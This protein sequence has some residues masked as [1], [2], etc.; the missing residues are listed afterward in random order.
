MTSGVQHSDD[1]VPW[2]ARADSGTGSAHA[3]L[4]PTEHRY[5]DASPQPVSALSPSPGAPGH[6]PPPPAPSSLA[7][8]RPESKA[9]SA[10]AEMRQPHHQLSHGTPP[11]GH[12]LNMQPIIP[13]ASV[14]ATTFELD[15]TAPLR[16]M[17]NPSENLS[18]PL[19]ANIERR[20]GLA[21]V[22]EAPSQESLAAVEP[23]ARPGPSVVQP[24]A[25]K[26]DD[27]WG[28]SFKIEWIRTERLPFHRTRHLRNPWNHGREVK[29]SRDGTELE[30]S[31]GRDLLAEWDRPPPDPGDAG[32][33]P[34]RRR[35]PHPPS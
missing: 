19:P 18:E 16:K 32:K 20:M 28:H 24:A 33:A 6:V 22:T 8:L 10:P 29:V 21:A 7:N 5:A 1:R 23:T 34:S 17:R 12:S 15:T 26:A 11:G 14:P 25:D 35:Q 13:A 9:S 30:P 31:V 2:E 27:S 3:I 4:S